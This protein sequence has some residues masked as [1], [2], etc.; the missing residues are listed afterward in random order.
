MNISSLIFAKE[1]IYPILHT[2]RKEV[3]VGFLIGVDR[4]VFVYYSDNWQNVL[5]FG[6]WGPPKK[7]NTPL[8]INQ[9]VDLLRRTI[10]E[11][12]NAETITKTELLEGLEKLDNERIVRWILENQADIERNVRPLPTDRRE[13]KLF[14]KFVK[15]LNRIRR[16]KIEI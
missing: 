12:Y 8:L 1:R 15:E 13:Q 3:D 11:E 5:P 6:K 7:R 14:Q 10:K 2:G 9:W 16:E 4:S